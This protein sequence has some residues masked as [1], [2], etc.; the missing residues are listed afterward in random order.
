MSELVVKRWTRYGNDRAYVNT[1]D[2]RRLGHLD[3]RTGV[4]TCESP[5]DEAAMRDALVDAGFLPTGTD[6]RPTTQRS[7]PPMAAAHPATAPAGSST[8]EPQADEPNELDDDLADNVPGEAIR[9]QAEIALA[10]MKERSRVRTFLARAT[11]AHT[12]ERAWR[13]GAEGEEAVAAQLARLE[14]D[15]WRFL[16]S[17]PVGSRGSDIDHVAIGPGGV[18][19][20]NTKNHRGKKVWVGN[21]SIRVGGYPVHYIRNAAF[22]AER[23]SRMLTERCGFPVIVNGVL[24][25]I[26]DEITVKQQP[27]EVTVLGRR[28]IRRWLQRQGTHLESGQIDAIFEVARRP[29]TWR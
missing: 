26:A 13:R 22:E 28:Q 5:H 2:M 17:I 27:D 14:R 15:G 1:V 6:P 11:D 24:A 21:R 23:A 20:I 18:F 29:A 8:A 25:V 4:I 12:D 19:T 16:H 7:T 3:L 10:T 9:E